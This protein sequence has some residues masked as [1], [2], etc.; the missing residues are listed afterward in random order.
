MMDSINNTV[1]E[2]REEGYIKLYRTITDSWVFA[3]PEKLKVWIWFLT[4]A[5]FKSRYIS[6]NVGNGQSIIGLK[7][8]EFVFGRNTAANE[9]CMPGSTIYKII[10]QF[11]DEGMVKIRSSNKYSIITICK[12]DAYQHDTPLSVAAEE[13]HDSSNRATQD[14]MVAAREFQQDTN[15][16]G[17]KDNK[18]KKER[19]EPPPK[20]NLKIRQEEF[21]KEIDQFTEHNESMRRNFYNYWSEPNH[22]KTKMKFELEKTWDTSRRL[23]KWKAN[24]MKFPSRANGHAVKSHN[25]NDQW[26]T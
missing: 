15:K 22:S 8:G 25:V 24:D 4:K 21:Q 13:G 10:K 26:N 18:V 5:S 14:N 3:H 19:E 20:N 2:G 6:L 7:T 12:W 16:K 23:Y 11:E 17:K 1:F 9:L